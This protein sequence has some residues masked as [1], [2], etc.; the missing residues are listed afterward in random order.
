MRR[1]SCAYFGGGGRSWSATGLA[2]SLLN[3]HSEKNATNQDAKNQAL[4]P[5]AFLKNISIVDCRFA[6]A[7]QREQSHKIRLGPYPFDTSVEW[8][9][10]SLLKSNLKAHYSCAK[11]LNCLTYTNTVH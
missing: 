11:E 2:T 6:I 5:S 1:G 8:S 9:L 4:A 10:T 7:R 3:E